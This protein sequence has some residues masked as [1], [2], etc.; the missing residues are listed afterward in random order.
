MS[1][2]IKQ[3]LIDD[4]EMAGL[5]ANTRKTYLDIIVRFVRR[6]RTRP[7]DATEEQVAEYLR[8]LI[9]QGLC[10]GTLKPTRSA[11]SFVFQHTLRRQWGLFKKGSTA[12]VASV[13]P[14]PPAMPSA[15]ASSPPCVSRSTVSAWL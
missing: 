2:S 1:D 4:L 9:R 8:G 14:R 7:Q 15:A 5:A 11:L 3:Q 13:C 6:T 10:Q 12:R